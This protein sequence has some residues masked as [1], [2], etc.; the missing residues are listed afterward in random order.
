M[1]RLFCAYMIAATST[2]L[3]STPSKS[4]TKFGPTDQVSEPLTIAEIE[5]QDMESLSNDLKVRPD[6][7]KVPFR[8]ANP[9]WKAFKAMFR[10][11]DKIVRYS[12]DSHSWQ[13]LAGETGYGLLRS[14]CLIGKFRTMWN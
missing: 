12:T 3:A 13:H 11:G 6:L 8:F 4:C 7:P 10:P 5:R 2:A 9:E 14:G 1:R